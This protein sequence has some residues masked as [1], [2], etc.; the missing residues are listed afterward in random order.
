MDLNH[1]FTV[2][3][4]PVGFPTLL[5]T[6][7]DKDEK[8]LDEDIKGIFETKE[9]DAL[10]PAFIAIKS[11]VNDYPVWSLSCDIDL[12]ALNR[13]E[14]AEKDENIYTYLKGEGPKIINLQ[15][16]YYSCPLP[17][18]QIIG[19]LN[20]VR[21]AP[22]TPK[23]CVIKRMILARTEDKNK[24]D[25]EQIAEQL[26][27]RSSEIAGF[28]YVSP[29][30]TAMEY[31]SKT[32]RDVEA[33]D[34]GRIEDNSEEVKKGIR[35]R[36]RFNKFKKEVCTQCFVRGFCRGNRYCDGAY[37]KTSGDAVVEILDKVD[38]PFTDVQLNYLLANSGELPK[39]VDR[40]IA[41]ATFQLI[42][43]EL[44][45]GIVPRCG[46][47]NMKIKFKSFEEAKK[48]LNQHGQD[49]NPK[50]IT[51]IPLERKAVL[52]ELASHDYSPTNNCGW[53]RTSYRVVGIRSYPDLELVFKHT[54]GQVLRWPFR[55]SS[56]TSV[57]E[58][59]ESLSL[60]RHTK[61]PLNRWEYH[62]NK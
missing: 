34:F 59:Y 40:R 21:E 5:F 36:A 3:G 46:Y 12:W 53:H 7:L 6:R 8:Q 41:W 28:V 2:A 14:N 35:E 26:K 9:I 16:V 24:S 19:C 29:K 22:P 42:E 43:G 52:A 32:F 1:V 38:I 15:T 25:V 57:Y 62:R 56:L 48:F 49:F 44:V 45:F 51:P 50:W 4:S 54:N 11:D 13:L 55:V 23:D 47:Y 61:S 20:C 37:P 18:R 17:H 30:L 58:H 31:F 10:L 60:L 27:N 33:H 39:R